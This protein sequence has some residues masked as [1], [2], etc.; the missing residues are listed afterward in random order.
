MGE[1]YKAKNYDEAVTNYPAAI[2]ADPTNHT[3][4]SN[5]S[6]ANSSKGHH[7]VLSLQ[8]RRPALPEQLHD[9]PDG[10][11]ACG[12]APGRPRLARHHLRPHQGPRQ[13]RGREARAV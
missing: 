7:D 6:A 12:E 8:M 11:H 13:P 4:Y 1:A 3:L 2:D 9:G 5:R 10:R